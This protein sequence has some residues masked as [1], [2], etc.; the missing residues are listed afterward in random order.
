MCVF[1]SVVWCMWIFWCIYLC[2]MFV[3]CTINCS[4]FQ[5]S[6]F[7]SLDV[8]SRHNCSIFR[9]FPFMINMY[10]P[11]SCHLGHQLSAF[12]IIARRSQAIETK[13]RWASGSEEG[14]LWNGGHARLVGEYSQL[15]LGS[16]WRRFRV[17]RIQE[18]SGTKK[19]EVLSRLVTVLWGLIY[20]F[21]V[22]QPLL[23]N[24]LF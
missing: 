23:W 9:P 3:N 5:V 15:H 24:C 14:Q 10:E 20:G 16:P 1:I 8:K 12:L 7:K 22:K 4:V 13:A 18:S 21:K 2:F 6:V 17:S 11:P 19:L